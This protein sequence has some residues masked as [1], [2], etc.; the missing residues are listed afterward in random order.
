MPKFGLTDRR[1]KA[2][3]RR[4]K[5]D[6]SCNPPLKRPKIRPSSSLLRQTYF[7]MNVSWALWTATLLLMV[8]RLFVIKNQLGAKPG[9]AA[10]LQ[11]ILDAAFFV[12]LVSGV[13][14]LAMLVHSC[15]HIATT[16]QFRKQ[17]VQN[18]LH[19][20][21]RCGYDISNRVN[22]EP[23]PECGQYISRRELVRIWCK[24]LH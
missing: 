22:E 11:P 15:V 14:L 13:F 20:C 10:S 1:P 6:G 19:N 16:R 24:A 5:P 4:A 17:V 2:W 23:C 9:N 8:I 18:R 3:S 12:Q 7:F 21:P